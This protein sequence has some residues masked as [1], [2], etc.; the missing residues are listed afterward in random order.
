MKNKKQTYVALFLTISLII[1]I[2]ILYNYELKQLVTI[3][4]LIS[5][6]LYFFLIYV[7]VGALYISRFIGIVLFFSIFLLI[8]NLVETIN[9]QLYPITYT[10]FICYLLLILGKKMF[11]NWKNNTG[12]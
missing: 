6:C 9:G 11:N 7:S 1:L 5:Y 2:S 8:P 4:S 10:V 3:S 12:M